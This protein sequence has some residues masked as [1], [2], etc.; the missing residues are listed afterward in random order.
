MKMTEIGMQFDDIYELNYEL[1]NELE[2]EVKPDGT[3]YDPAGNNIIFFNG[4]KVIASTRA[5]NIHYAGQGEIPFDILNNIR[6]TTVLF[7]NYLERRMA[8]G[9]PFVSFFPDEQIIPGE[10]LTDPDI[11]ISNLTVKFDNTH[12]LSSPYFRNKCLKFIYMIFMLEDDLVD[13]TNFD[14]MEALRFGEGA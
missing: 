10:K 4:M 11:K 6:M 5:D 14:A 1:L 3:I 13:L 9:M 2:F 8:K 12:E 7:G